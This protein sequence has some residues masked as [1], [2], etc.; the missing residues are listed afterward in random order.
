VIGDGLTFLVDGMM[1]I[2]VVVVVLAA[3]DSATWVAVANS[4][5]LAVYLLLAP[6]GGAIVDRI[7]LRRLL[8]VLTTGQA[9]AYGACA[10]TLA[11]DR[12]VVA[13]VAATT[14]ATACS[15]V[16]DSA[17][18]AVIVFV[19]DEDDL[20][21]ANAIRAGVWQVALL[22]APAAAALVLAV[23]GGAA[24]FGVIAVLAVASASAFSRIGPVTRPATSESSPS[25]WREITAGVRLVRDRPVLR[26]MVIV[27]M[28]VW[29]MIGAER[30]VQVLVTRDRLGLDSDAVGLLAAVAATGG[31]AVLPLVR[32]AASSASTGA[33]L[34]LSALCV[35][36]PFA[37]LGR[38]DSVAVAV[39]VLLLGGAG[40]ALF[41]VALPT[42]MQRSS[43]RRSIG[44]VNGVHDSVT[45][46]AD[47]VGATIATVLVAT[48]SIGTA[49][50]VT[51]AI[52]VVAG[53]ATLP[54]FRADIAR[55]R[56]RRAV[57]A[58]TL[59][60]LSRYE[61]LQGI[62]VGAFERLAESAAYRP[63]AAGTVIIREGDPADRLYLVV[64]GSFLATSVTEGRL[65]T[66]T[67]GDWFGEIGVLRRSPR[68]ATVTAETDA[69]VW[70]IDGESFAEAVRPSARG[71]AALDATM[72]VRLAR[73]PGR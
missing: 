33:A 14:I 52:G 66:M 20:G 10:V 46:L 40:R 73:T 34:A 7:D 50:A 62:G 65:S 4:A 70:E 41:D 59:D 37:F 28:S 35:G 12:G 45:S 19:V 3:T 67:A 21:G 72:R 42:V 13:V 23:G 61:I 27:S 25:V 24:A 49:M 48:T 17:R 6:V 63:V 56:A 44:R 53:L 54:T 68:T 36:V 38:V 30:V 2:S 58:P 5:R 9:I 32:R 29:A 57:L 43:P 1:A 18:Q 15:T 22:V 16:L 26:C 64:H 55:Q 47:I 8:V 71:H 69:E 60:A 31:L 11:A 39:A 51:G